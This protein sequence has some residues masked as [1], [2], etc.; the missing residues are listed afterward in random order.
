[1]VILCTISYVCFVFVRW[2]FDFTGSFLLTE[3]RILLGRFV[4][5]AYN[6]VWTRNESFVLY[7]ETTVHSIGACL[8]PCTSLLV[9]PQ[10]VVAIV[11]LGIVT[12]LSSWPLTDRRRGLHLSKVLGILAD[13][14]EW[15]LR[16]S[17]HAASLRV[18]RTRCQTYKASKFARLVFTCSL[19]LTW[20]VE[21]HLGSELMD[22]ILGVISSHVSCGGHLRARCVEL[23]LISGIQRICTRGHHW[24]VFVF[25]TLESWRGKGTCRCVYHLAPFRLIEIPDVAETH[26]FA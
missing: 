26:I 12:F 8:G 19:I 25:R 20:R 17:F 3:K 23:A 5:L 10:A 15:G 9:D 6:A 7:L 1:M 18:R 14:A 11:S 4:E 22:G 16:G 24:Q 2:N 21:W 13:Q